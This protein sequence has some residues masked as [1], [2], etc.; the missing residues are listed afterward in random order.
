MI[1]NSTSKC[2]V[3]VAACLAIAS[4][5]A[6]KQYSITVDGSGPK[7]G[8]NGDGQNGHIVV[9]YNDT[10]MWK[11]GNVNNCQS[12]TI[13]FTTSTCQEAMNLSGQRITCTIID[14]MTVDLNKYTL[15]VMRPNG[16]TTAPDDPYVIVDNQGGLPPAKRK[17][18]SK[19]SKP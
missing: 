1:K 19:L 13:T 9:Q 18:Q 6:A 12:M 10:V 5:C 16:S 3:L 17:P 14:M 4:A 11:C 8:Y 15:T 7:P 2:M